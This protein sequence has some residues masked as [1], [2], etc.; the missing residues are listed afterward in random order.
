[1]P[2][3]P[4]QRSKTGSNTSA[5]KP[6]ADAQALAE[7]NAR[8]KQKMQETTSPRRWREEQAETLKLEKLAEREKVRTGEVKPLAPEPDPIQSALLVDMPVADRVNLWLKALDEMEWGEKPEASLVQAVDLLVYYRLR[9]EQPHGQKKDGQKPTLRTVLLERIA[10]SEEDIVEVGEDGKANL[11]DLGEFFYKTVSERFGTAAI[12]LPD[13]AE[14]KKPD[15]QIPCEN[16]TQP[17]RELFDR[18]SL[19][20][21]PT[22]FR[23]GKVMVEMVPGDQNKPVLE[24]VSANRLI[25]LAEDFVRPFVYTEKNVKVYRRMR[26]S[27]ARPLLEIHRELAKL[28]SLN[29]LAN[30]PVLVETGDGKTEII[31]P[32]YH[33][34]TGIYVTGGSVDECG[35]I[36]ESA[37][38]LQM[39]FAEF[40]F[41]T[42]A[43]FARNMGLLITPA[44]VLGDLLG[45]RSAVDISEADLSQA[46]KGLRQKLIAAYYN[47]VLCDIAQPERGGVGSLEESF[48]T[49]LI[50]GNH[51]IRLDNYRG[52]LKSQKIEAFLTSDS[53][54]AALPTSPAGLST[55]PGAWS[56]SAAT[57]WP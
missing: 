56:T 8:L 31:K 35:S 3:A 6:S 21:P 27:D 52:E 2:E 39:A 47:D 49:A 1:M 26:E 33:K 50:H 11:T 40:K 38:I 23:Q 16:I 29:V 41:A 10:E 12:G 7:E 22:V 4:T 28:P 42:D 46:G 45:E 34:A 43:D 37:E 36:K 19:A 44:L 20:E 48:D 18:M 13:I 15:W 53:Y 17:A 30:A 57:A 54:I 5:V 32:G 55:P 9:P 51:F 24:E 14:G 25:S